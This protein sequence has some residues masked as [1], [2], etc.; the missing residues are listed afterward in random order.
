MERALLM[1]LTAIIASLVVMA[2][3]ADAQLTRA[4]TA[5]AEFTVDQW[6]TVDGLPQNSVNAI[7]QTPEGYIW[8][9]TFGGLARFDGLRFVLVERSDSAGRHVDRVLSLAVAPDSALWVGTENGL[10]RYAAGQFTRFSAVDGLPGR[11]IHAIHFDRRGQLWAGTERGVARFENRRFVGIGPQSGVSAAVVSFT[12]DRDGVLWIN[13]NGFFATVAPGTSQLNRSPEMARGGLHAMLLQDRDG[14]RWFARVDGLARERAGHVENFRI[15]FGP[16]LMIQQAH[17]GRFWWATPED[18]VREFRSDGGG[19][20]NVYPLPDGTIKYGARAILDGLDGNVW[21]GTVRDGLLRLKRNLFTTYGMAHGLTNDIIAAVMEA[22]DGSLWAGMNCGGVDIIDSRRR[23]LRRYAI[24]PPNEPGNGGCVFAL[25]Q[26]SSGAIWA[27]TWGSGLTRIVD[28]RVQHLGRLGVIPDSVIFALFTDRRGTVWAGTNSAGLVEVRNGRVKRIYTTAHGLGHNSVRVIRQT[29]DGA[30]WVGTMEGLSRIADD[31]RITT[32]TGKHG[33][34]S[35]HIRSI[36]QDADGTIW[37]GTFGGGLNRL[38]DG[39]FAAITRDD[40]LADNVISAIL[41]DAQGNLWMSGNRGVF[42]VAKQQLHDFADGKVRHVHSV[43]YGAGDGLVNAETNGGFQPAAWKDRRG[44]LWFPTI[45]GLAS[46]DPNEA[47]NI[48]RPPTV[49]VDELVVDGE[50]LPINQSLKIGPGRANVEF[51]YAGVSLTSPE[52]VTFR[53]RL[54]P[55]ENEWVEPGSRRTAYYSSLPAGEYRF[56][57]SAA[58]RDGVWSPTEAAV[59]VTVLAPLY[60]RVWF[61]GAILTLVALTLWSAHR[62][63]LRARTIAI[64]N[65][66]SRLAREIHDS[67]LQGVVGIALQLQAASTRLALPQ[68]Q[69]PLIEDVLAMID[70]TLT[71]A[72]HAVWDLRPS[73]EK[74]QELSV[75][76]HSA[77]QRIFVGGTPTVRVV[78]HGRRRSLSTI[79]ETECLRIVEEALTNVRKHADARHVVVLLDYR[80]YGLRLRIRDD[81]KGFDAKQDEKRPGHWGWLGMRERASR[82]GSKLVL[83]SSVGSGT[84]ISFEVPYRPTVL[85]WFNGNG[86]ENDRIS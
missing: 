27:G 46:V 41:E 77:A 79:A 33:L 16:E 29:A 56:L 54:E 50:T 28:G 8:V 2:P 4:L 63:V 53:Y 38:R 70:R 31:S 30:I 6:T 51:R 68:S 58:N 18:G 34:S 43:L 11:E 81:G 55:L 32:F 13:S 82:I 19:R 61:I 15:G 74:V 42:R 9:G 1:R 60:R 10:L 47:V 48:P 20:V 64:R 25:T 17:D 78:T 26:D 76:C 3:P 49:A 86:R 7:A 40:G 14:D 44:K 21:V 66:R 72:R 35:E 23:S 62:A 65:E 73:G 83:E 85:S 52:N 39:K 84:T 5:P 37:I 22:R 12:E 57:V 80:W 24:G 59:D 36:H 67:L 69:R 71:Q 75:E 45:Q